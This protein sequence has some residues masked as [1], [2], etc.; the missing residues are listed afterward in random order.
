MVIRAC[1]DL[2][3]LDWGKQ[4]HA[5]II[6][7]EVEFDSALGSSLVNLYGKCGDLDSASHALNAM[8]DPDDF[9]LSAMISGYSNCGRIDEARR[10]FQMCCLWNSIIAGYVTNC[11]GIEAL[12][13]FGA[14]RKSG[15]REDSSTFSSIL[16]ACSTLGIREYRKQIHAHASKFGFVDDLIVVT[17]LVYTCGRVEDAKRVFETMRSKSLISWNSMIVGLSQNGCPLEALDLSVR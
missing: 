3:A 13:L 4:I 6:A 11:Q 5:R 14:M 7:E 1:T 9:S 10:I 15:V 8:D 16:N 17:A 12:V 2:L